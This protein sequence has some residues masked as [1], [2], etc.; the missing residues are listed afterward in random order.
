MSRLSILS[1]IFAGCLIAACWGPAARPQS[2]PAETRITHP[3]GAA[4]VVRA[5]AARDDSIV[6]TGRIAN[7]TDRELR[8]NRS[9]SFVLEGAG[10]AVHHLNPPIGNAELTIPPRSQSGAELV[11][12]GPPASAAHELTLSTNR[13]IGTADNPYD[14]APVLRTILPVGSRA[15]GTAAA[16]Q[17]SH[18]NGATLR[19][20]RLVAGHGS[21]IASLDATN[22]NDRTILL[23]QSGGMVLTDERGGTA[24]LK[25]PTENRELVV[26]PSTRLD[27]ELAFDCRQIDAAGPLTLHTNRGTPGTTD[28]PYDTLPVFALRIHAEIAAEGS[29]MPPASRASVT[30]IARSQLT[31]EARPAATPAAAPT[32]EPAPVKPAPASTPPSNSPA[33]VAEPAPPPSKAPKTAEQLK[34]ALRT[35][36]TDRGSRLVV[37]SDTLFE[38]AGK[39]LRGG[40]APLLENLAALVA[41]EQAREVVVIAHTDSMGSDADNMALSEDRARAV[42]GWLKA[43]AGKPPPRFVAKS[44]GR[45]RPVAPNHNADGEDNPEGRAQN[46][47]IE[48]LIRRR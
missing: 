31:P 7:P 39:T 32:A 27:A 10:R 34:A 36:K 23:N 33:P 37:P 14:D 1:R 5:L 9:R 43:H 16:S 18:P 28:N 3:N 29:A 45:T 30:P 20:R 15:G 12:I 26:P 6:L 13:G 24:T 42:A 22:G 4:I 2:A 11:F 25:A 44:Y 19:V 48:V 35:E 8:L 46:R 40:A 38:P 21:C 41:A 17:A 47:R